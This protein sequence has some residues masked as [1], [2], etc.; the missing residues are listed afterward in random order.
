VFRFLHF[1]G[2]SHTIRVREQ[3]MSQIQACRQQVASQMGKT[4][5]IRHIW[6]HRAAVLGAIVDTFFVG[7]FR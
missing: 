3:W 7:S 4:C 2:Y 1:L 5:R 6:T